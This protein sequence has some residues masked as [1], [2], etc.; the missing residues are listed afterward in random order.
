MSDGRK[1]SRNAMNKRVQNFRLLITSGMFASLLLALVFAV[2][3]QLHERIHPDTAATQ[4]EC[5]V[6]LI[7]SGKYQQS[8]APV[9]VSAPQPAVQF[10]KIPALKSV[11]VPA[12]FLGACIFEHA[13]PAL[14]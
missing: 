13:P 5:A 7:A 8:E 10:S 12:P 11:W 1:Q 9:L 4:H 14:S 6:T 2:A 3:P